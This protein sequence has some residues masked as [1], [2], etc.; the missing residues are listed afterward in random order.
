MKYNE[1]KLGLNHID[2]GLSYKS[3]ANQYYL[4]GSYDNALIYFKKSMIISENK[5]GSNHINTAYFYRII[6]YIYI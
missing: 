5:L 6:G 1:D 2:T 3:I 4:L